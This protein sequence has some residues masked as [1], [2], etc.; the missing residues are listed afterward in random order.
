MSIAELPEQETVSADAEPSKST[1]CRIRRR[2][3]AKHGSK[4]GGPP[5]HFARR[6]RLGGAS[7]APRRAR[8][9]SARG[10]CLAW[11]GVRQGTDC[12]TPW[13]GVVVFGHR[14]RDIRRSSGKDAADE[15]LAHIAHR[16]NQGA[17]GD[18]GRR[19]RLLPS[20]GPARV[21]AAGR[22]A[23]RVARQRGRARARARAAR[24]RSDCHRDHV[25]ARAPRGRGR[26]RG[27]QGRVSVGRARRGRG[28]EGS[29]PDRAHSVARRDR[30][31]LRRFVGGPAQH[32]RGESGAGVPAARRA[33]AGAPSRAL[34]AAAVRHAWPR[35]SPSVCRPRICA[36]A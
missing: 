18:P 21:G 22:A 29:G 25:S 11:S 4:V 5:Q 16:T 1:P 35:P 34:S 19:P 7:A 31:R 26:D 32:R 2:H 36:A 33:G 14:F 3:M 12:V 15:R 13:S 23:D 27:A 17:P 8:F 6:C 10:A 9:G 30:D 24:R 28:R 20:G